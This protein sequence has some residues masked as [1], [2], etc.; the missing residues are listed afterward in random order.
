MKLIRCQLKGYTRLLLNNIQFIDYS[1][2]HKIQLIL[3]SNGAGKSS[4]IKELSPLPADHREYSKDGFKVIEYHHNNSHYTLKSLF[5]SSGN[6]YHFIKDGEALNPGCTLT[7]FRELVKQEFFITP[8]IHELM[9]GVTTFSNMSISERRNWFTK[10]SDADYTYAIRYYQTLKDKHRDLTGA[11]KQ[12]QSRLVQESEKL[13]TPDKEQSYREDISHLSDLLTHFLGL[14]HYTSLNK[15]QLEES[16]EKTQSQLSLS[17]ET[18]RKQIRKIYQIKTGKDT[19]LYADHTLAS[20]KIVTLKGD[21]AVCHS[22]SRATIQRVTEI[23]TM[24]NALKSSNIESFSDIDTTVTSLQQ[25]LITLKG[26]F[27]YPQLE[28]SDPMHALEALSATE[29]ELSAIF[30]QLPPNPNKS[31]YTREQW[32]A[33]SELR[34]QLQ[35]RAAKLERSHLEYVAK[36]QQLEHAKVHDRIDCPQCKHSWHKDYSES[37]YRRV[38]E[39]IGSIHQDLQDTKTEQERVDHYLTECGEYFS[40][41]KE[42]SRVRKGFSVFNEFWAMVDEKGWVFETPGRLTN[43]LPQLR[44]DLLA[45]LEASRVKKR[46]DDA[47]ELK[48]TL[49]KNQDD[50]L[51][52]LQVERARLESQLQEQIERKESIQ[53][54]I[55]RLEELLT[56]YQH[57]SASVTRVE[58]IVKLQESSL[59]EAI[60]LERNDHLNRV[61]ELTKLELTQREQIISRIDIQKAL[62]SHME[63]QIQEMAEQAQVLKYALRELSP[64]EGLIARGLTGFINHFITRVNHFIKKVWLYPLELT[65]ISPEEDL[66]LDYKFKIKV[67]DRHAVSDISKGSSGMKEIIDL[68]FKVTSMKYLGLE[69]APLHLDEFGAR[70]DESHRRSAHHAIVQLMNS[71]NFSQIFMISHYEHSYGSLKNCDVTVLSDANITIPKEMAYNTHVKFS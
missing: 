15:R 65:P 61:I 54:M 14:K 59:K 21:L 50:S 49:S 53:A 43:E 71:S 28:Y 47:A 7:V 30:T 10:I 18:I 41:F 29:S 1:P 2:V 63:S 57:L 42:Y 60:T 44:A 3:G 12:Q 17:A 58:D 34:Q 24:L 23:D 33:Q 35:N 36:K 68:A 27:Q 66:D 16:R 25:S 26:T 20:E 31:K 40:L 52:G 55:V 62:V 5:S 70:L 45:H 32:V 51:N 46:L 22:Q 64:T 39:L 37:E 69:Y 38:C 56:A 11:I 48:R 19:A 4:L 13:I 8:D 67:N 6:E 9:T